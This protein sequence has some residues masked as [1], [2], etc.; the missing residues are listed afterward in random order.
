[1]QSIAVSTSFASSS[2]VSLIRLIVTRIDL[3]HGPYTEKW[4]CCS[5]SWVSTSVT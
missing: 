2:S 4:G 5:A 1:M 3:G